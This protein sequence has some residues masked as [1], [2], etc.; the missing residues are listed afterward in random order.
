MVP[1]QIKGGLFLAEHAAFPPPQL[2]E[3]LE[4]NLNF[5]CV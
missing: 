3:T 1:P 5:V 2:A 4:I